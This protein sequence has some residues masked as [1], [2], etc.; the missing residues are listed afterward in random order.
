[1]VLYFLISASLLIRSTFAASESPY[2]QALFEQNFYMTV[3]YTA[4]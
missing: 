3:Q 4:I 2:S 1:V